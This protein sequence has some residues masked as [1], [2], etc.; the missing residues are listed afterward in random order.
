VDNVGD[1]ATHDVKLEVN[2]STGLTKLSGADWHDI[3]YVDDGSGSAVYSWQFSKDDG[4]LQAIVLRATSNSYG[5]YFADALVLGG[6]KIYLPLI[7]K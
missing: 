7:F 3:G 5:E 1:L 2:S 4:S 6:N